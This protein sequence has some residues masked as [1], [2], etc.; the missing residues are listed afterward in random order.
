MT[1]HTIRKDN[2]ILY[3]SNFYSLPLGSYKGPNS[4]VYSSINNTE[5]ILYNKDTGKVITKHTISTDKGKLISQAEHRRRNSMSIDN[6]ED[7][8]LSHFSNSEEIKLYLDNLKEN[9]GR[10]Y[11]DNIKHLFNNLN[12][13]SKEELLK[14]IVEQINSNIYN[15]GYLLPSITCQ[16]EKRHYMLNEYNLQPDKRSI[17][18]YKSIL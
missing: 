8:I 16:E 17:N 3:R 10:Y 11:L 7:K 15:T 2:T 14:A 18:T 13:Y 9:K 4:V 1:T 12:N 6:I 5:L